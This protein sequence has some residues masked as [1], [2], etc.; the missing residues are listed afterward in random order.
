MRVR[1]GPA[2]VTGERTPR[3]PRVRPEGRGERRSGEPGDWAARGCHR[4][5]HDAST[6]HSVRGGR[7]APDQSAPGEVYVHAPPV[8]ARCTGTL[9]PGEAARVRLVTADPATGRV[10]FTAVAVRPAV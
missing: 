4:S 7:P 9:R 10:A 5:G 3:R 6:P 2:T 1:R 8:L